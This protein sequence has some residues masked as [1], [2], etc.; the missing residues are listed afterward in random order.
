MN[1]QDIEQDLNWLAKTPGIIASALVAIDT[2]MIYLAT[3]VEEQF[4]KEEFEIIAE[5][6]RD[7]WVL[8]Q[9][10]GKVFD[11]LGSVSSIVVQHTKG[12]LSIRGCG[13]TMLLITIAKMKQVEWKEWSV[14][15]NQLCD[16]VKKVESEK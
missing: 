14:K 11:A 7:Y 2:G 12:L 9:K 8:H 10:N 3:S 5:G 6:S 13:H 16:Q 1:Y 4:E 15:F